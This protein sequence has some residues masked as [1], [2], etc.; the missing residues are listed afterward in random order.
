MMRH[1]QIKFIVYPTQV[2]DLQLLLESWLLYN[3][4]EL[5]FFETNHDK[6]PKEA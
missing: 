3:H 5:T 1:N 4:E 6:V 2:S